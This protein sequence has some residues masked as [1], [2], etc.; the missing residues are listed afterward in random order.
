MWV[1]TWYFILSMIHLEV[2]QEGERVH[3]GP[4]LSLSDLVLPSHFLTQGGFM[5][6]GS[7]W[8]PRTLP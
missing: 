3:F 5:S 8:T 1:I 4:A 7:V 2:G 6:W